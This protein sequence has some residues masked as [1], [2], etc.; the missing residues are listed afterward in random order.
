MKVKYLTV[1]MMP[2]FFGL[3]EAQGAAD[4]SVISS[5]ATIGLQS[6][7]YKTGNL[8]A[9]VDA[10]ANVDLSLLFP[11][12]IGSSKDQFASAF[13]ANVERYY[14]RQEIH[15]SIKD[16]E[17]NSEIPLAVKPK[18]INGALQTNPF[19][20]NNVTLTFNQTIEHYSNYPSYNGVIGFLNVGK[21]N[22]QLN[23]MNGTAAWMKAQIITATRLG[24]SYQIGYPGYYGAQA[25]CLSKKCAFTPYTYLMF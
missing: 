12:D 14:P 6:T 18:T 15:L 19:Y 20:D 11:K 13:N 2:L 8:I 1:A 7:E 25:L 10:P 4:T 9:V 5:F 24:T 23:L 22:V 3:P 17:R 21:G 16:A